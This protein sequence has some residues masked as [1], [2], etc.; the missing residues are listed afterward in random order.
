[1]E[2]KTGTRFRDWLVARLSESKFGTYVDDTDEEIAYRLGVRVE[3][4]LEARAIF[5]ERMKREGLPDGQ[6]HGAKHMY[7]EEPIY[8]IFM[9]PPPPIY[10]AWVA[11]VEA[12]GGNN[13]SVLRGVVHAVLQTRTQPG[14]L[15][16][17]MRNSWIWKGQW[18]GH[19]NIREHRHRIA[20][21]IGEGADRALKERALA[22]RC[23]PTSI[24]RWGMNLF[25]CGKLQASVVSS[26]WAMYKD[27]KRYCV[28]PRIT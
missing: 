3:V 19:V 12:R 13:S 10:E 4:L 15:R 25:V 22:T 9:E 2:K 21:K 8:E 11:M 16:E 6:R 23:K 28:A 14:W 20:C 26:P 7:A 18:I 27:P 5:Q 17:R 1:L 24:V